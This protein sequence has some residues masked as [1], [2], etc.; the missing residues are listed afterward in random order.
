MRGEAPS[1]LRACIMLMR[2]DG[3]L[4]AVVMFAVVIVDFGVA[5]ILGMA[6]FIRIAVVL[7]IRFG[8]LFIRAFEIVQ[9]IE[10]AMRAY[11]AVAPLSESAEQTQDK[12]T[13]HEEAEG[14]PQPC[15]TGIVIGRQINQ[16]IHQRAAG[17]DDI[18][19]PSESFGSLGQ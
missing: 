3:L 10:C 19:G 11:K 18:I 7:Q 12:A 5:V 13:Q 17:G 14:M 8:T 9:A 4:P 1:A 16:Q 2:D 6:V 15:E